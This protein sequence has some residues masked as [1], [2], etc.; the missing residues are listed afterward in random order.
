MPT[1]QPQKPL[2]ESNANRGVLGWFGRIRRLLRGAHVESMQA[3]LAAVDAKDSYTRTHSLN[4]AAY[5]DAVAQRMDLSVPDRRTLQAASLLHDIGKIGIPDRILN[6]PGKLTEEEFAVMRRHPQMAVDILKPFSG[7]R[8]HRR[9]ILHHHERYDGGGYPNG[10][11]G[12]DI[13][14]GSRILAAV[15]AVDTMLSRR[16]YKAPMAAADVRK[17]LVSQAGIQFD[18]AV[19]SVTIGWMDDGGPESCLGGEA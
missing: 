14:L 16:T 1:T 8:D 9:I 13:P 4:V 17:E 3:L 7:L 11:R 6:K 12:E 5:A 10:C 15:D 18:P 19:V 2:K